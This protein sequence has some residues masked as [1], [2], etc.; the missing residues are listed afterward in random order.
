MTSLDQA[1]LLL[2]KAQQDEVIVQRLIDDSEITDESVGFHVQQA[3][4]KLLKALLAV[5]GI[6][7]PRTHDL[8]LLV[9][10]LEG[11]SCSLPADLLD[12]VEL[13]P[14]ATVFRYEELPLDES[15]PRDQ[16]L[17]QLARLRTFVEQKLAAG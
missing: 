6:D 1:R 5:Q 13:T 4:E 9:A 3:A 15:L 10:L 7:Y 2:R 11:T 14:M 8:D 12:I 17:A 16:W